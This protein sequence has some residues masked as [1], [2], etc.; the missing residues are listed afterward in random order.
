MDRNPDHGN[1][2]GGGEGVHGLSPRVR[3]GAAAA[4]AGTGCVMAGL[5]VGMAVGT[6]IRAVT[7][8]VSRHCG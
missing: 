3:S 7:L 1:D 6:G 5:V 8:P 2:D 4:A